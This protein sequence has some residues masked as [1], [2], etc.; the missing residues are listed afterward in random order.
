MKPK[1]QF[2]A[3]LT[4]LLMVVVSAACGTSTQAT[5]TAPA[6]RAEPTATQVEEPTAAP[7]IVPDL[8]TAR[9]SLKE[10]PKGFEEI[11]MQNIIEAQ[12]E[13]GEEEYMPDVFFTFINKENFQ[14]ILGMNYLLSNTIN[15]LGYG[16]ALRDS[17]NTLQKLAGALGGTNVREVETL[18]GLES[19]GDK[20]EAM[21][22]VSDVE[23]IPMRVDGVMFQ[24]GNVGS[25]LLSM[26][27]DGEPENISLQDLGS[28]LDQHIQESLDVGE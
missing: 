25:I 28:I 11:D 5:A 27:V 1:N 2:T 18:G 12:E 8:S 19:L 26:R 6:E 22:M 13:S 14:V 23:G 7:E 4:L 21:T 3:L 15:R 10:L 17:Q 20:Q 24:R 9:I 16:S